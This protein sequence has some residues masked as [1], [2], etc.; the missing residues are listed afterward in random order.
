M[1]ERKLIS[2]TFDDGPSPGV[3]DQVLEV[4]E[5]HGARASFFLIGRQIVPE[6]EHLIRRAL[7][8][9]CSI[10]NHSFTHPAM[11]KLTDEQILSEVRRTTERIVAVTGGEPRFFR[12][13]YIDVDERMY[14]LIP[15][16]FICG[17]GCEDWVPA[18]TAQER[19]RR[20]LAAAKDGAIILV[21]DMKDN[22]ATAEAVEAVITALQPQ[23]YEF[24]NIRELF[25]AKGTAI[26]HGT[27]YSDV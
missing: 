18:V 10:E 22:L 4:L 5:R 7:S 11:T 17:H 8:D 24:V 20:I 13:P 1:S 15:Y 14:G 9:G 23:G 2:L 19:T 25:A 27:L 26:D 21:H 6:T 3:T 12:P 16:T